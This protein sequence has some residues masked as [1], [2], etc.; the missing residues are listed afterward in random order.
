MLVFEPWPTFDASKLVETQMT[1][2]VS[3][4]GKRAAEFVVAADAD[5]T[6]VIDA[7]KAAAGAK[8]DGVEIVKTVVVPKKLVNFVVKK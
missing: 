6:A 2:V 7:A 1:N 3:I 4:N 5:E 8:L